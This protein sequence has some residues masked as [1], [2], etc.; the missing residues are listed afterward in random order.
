MG[1]DYDFA[2]TDCPEEC[3]VGQCDCDRD[4]GC[5]IVIVM[6][7]LFWLAVAIGVGLVREWF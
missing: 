5:A 6:C 1:G 4:P 3:P 7:A 2:D